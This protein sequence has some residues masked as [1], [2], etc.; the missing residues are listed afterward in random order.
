MSGE[1][2][3]QTRARLGIIRRGKPA[4]SFIGVPIHKE[5]EVVGVI[6][7]QDYER[8]NVYTDH[9]LELLTTIAAQVSSALENAR[10]YSEIQVELEVRK[11]AGE[12]AGA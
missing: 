2:M 6:A 8:T 4:L 7:L 5:H 3:E 11:R 9:H 1:D 10:L 12:I